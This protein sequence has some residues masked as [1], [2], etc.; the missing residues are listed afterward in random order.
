MIMW[1]TPSEVSRYK[2]SCLLE[3]SPCFLQLQVSI[4]FLVEKKGVRLQLH[5]N[6]LKLNLE[7]GTWYCILIYSNA[8]FLECS[9]KVLKLLKQPEL[10]LPLLM[11]ESCRSLALVLLCFPMIWPHSFPLLFTLFC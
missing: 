4:W 6:H 3:L 1:Q 10:Q 5:T 2:D 7:E 9:S 11:K 8:A